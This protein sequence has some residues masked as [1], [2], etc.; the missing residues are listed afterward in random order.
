VQTP[1]ARPQCKESWKKFHGWKGAMKVHVS[2]LV[3]MPDQ[4][5]R[6]LTN[7]GPLGKTGGNAEI[8]RI[9]F[10]AD[11]KT[12]KARIPYSSATMPPSSFMNYKT[13]IYTSWNNEGSKT[14]PAPCS[15]LIC[16]SGGVVA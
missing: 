7:N 11:S 12:K 2:E 1:R 6:G 4:R 10:W 15:L 3:S 5:S 14:L 16:C 8:V 13:A 9:V